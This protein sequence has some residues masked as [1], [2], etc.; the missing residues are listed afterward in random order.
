MAVSNANDF[1]V[2]G[3]LL[4]ESAKGGRRE[5]PGGKGRRA[6]AAGVPNSSRRYQGDGQD[7]AAQG[8]FTK[9][10][11]EEADLG[12]AT[13]TATVINR[14]PEGNSRD[15]EQ[16]ALAEAADSRRPEGV[17]SIE[18]RI[19]RWA[20]LYDAECGLCTWLLSRRRLR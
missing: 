15:V 2:D 4:G 12:R 20:H 10:A 8:S 9:A 16:D 14:K 3:Q 17:A 18:C 11:A 6:E 19:T 7:E 13:L 5:G 1:A